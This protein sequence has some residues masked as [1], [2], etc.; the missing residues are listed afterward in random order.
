MPELNT[1]NYTFLNI[2]EKIT[3]FSQVLK[4]VHTTENWFLFSASWC[5]IINRERGLVTLNPSVLNANKMPYN[6]R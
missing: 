3:C 4:E 6:Y 2:C 5:I 1:L